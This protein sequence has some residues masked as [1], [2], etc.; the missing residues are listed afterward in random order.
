MLQ[1]IGCELC[2]R[3]SSLQAAQLLPR[4]LTSCL[5]RTGPIKHRAELK[6]VA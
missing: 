6:G 4:A 2:E 1:A 3:L 5:Q